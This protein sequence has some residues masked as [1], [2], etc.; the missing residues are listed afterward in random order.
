M[1]VVLLHGF[2]ENKNIWDTFL[3]FLPKE[4]NYLLLDYSTLTFCQTIEDY[5]AWVHH[6]ITER[7][8]TRHVL[9]G[10]SMGGYISMAYAE[11]HSDYLSGLGLFH[12]TVYADSS[13]KK[14][15]REKTIAFI[16]KH[17]T[18]RFIEG[19]LPNMFSEAFRKKN[20]LYIKKTLKDNQSIPPEALILATGAMK[21][22]KDTQEV[23]ERLR[24]P[25]LKIIGKIDPFI[26]YADAL[27][28]CKLIKH[29]FISILDHVAHAGMLEDPHA[30]A[31]I[32]TA[33]LNAIDS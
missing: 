19:F 32:T 20:S 29:P 7:N 4:N 10:H 24:I 14:E 2:G 6:E 9:I 27:E 5:A 30:T 22:R 17:G 15:S 13:E 3:P 12:S 16:Q 25:L 31:A 11:K 18:E 23:L 26:P 8:I 33:F 1:D 28:Q 21:D